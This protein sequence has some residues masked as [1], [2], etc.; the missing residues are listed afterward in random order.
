[1]AKIEWCKING[2]DCT[3]TKILILDDFKLS[4]IIKNYSS[5]R[6][7]PRKLLQTRND[8]YFLTVSLKIKFDKL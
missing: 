8:I 1:M 6:K 5:L 3:S 4:T 7:I 2:S